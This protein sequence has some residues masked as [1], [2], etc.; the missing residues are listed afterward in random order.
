LGTI[1]A[2]TFDSTRIYATLGV[3]HRF[4]DAFAMAGSYTHIF[5]V[6]VDTKGENKLDEYVAQSK[7][8]SGDGKYGSTVM[9]LNLNATYS[10]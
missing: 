3:R 7:S 9:F 6:P 10:F 4:S 5:F 8:P 2:S 1:D